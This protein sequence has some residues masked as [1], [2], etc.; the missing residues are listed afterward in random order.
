MSLNCGLCKLNRFAI[1]TLDEIK[2]EPK[3]DMVNYIIKSLTDY[4]KKLSI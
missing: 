3:S 2:V 4:L 1:L